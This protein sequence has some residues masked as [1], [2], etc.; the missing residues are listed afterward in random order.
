MKVGY[1]APLP[2]VRSGVADYAADLLAALRQHCEPVPNGGGDTA[3]YQLGNNQM[4]HVIFQRALAE[5]GVI[6]L[7][8]A[9]L[10]HYHLGAL[11]EARYVSEFVK[12]YGT[13]FEDYAAMLWRGRAHSAS[14]PRYFEY[15]LLRT[16]ISRSRA[17]IVHNAA[18][19]RIATNEGAA[20]KLHVI[21]HLLPRIRPAHAQAVTRLR[22]SLGIAAGSTLFAVFGHLR[23]SKRIAGVVRAFARVHALAPHVR[24]LIAGESVSAPYA[25]ALE[26]LLDT[27]GI[28]RAGHLSEGD[29][30]TYASAADVCI[31]LRYPSCGETSGI[32]MRLMALGKPVLVTAGDEYGGFP[33]S[34]CIRI[35]PG[36]A[37]EEHLAQWMTLLHEN[38]DWATRI[39]E[40]GRSHVALYHAPDRVGRMVFDVLS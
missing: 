14:D 17:V 26:Q 38:R 3:L 10:H 40:N 2:P 31:N 15:P 33:E 39:G 11:N 16:V 22:Q 8:D 20:G 19:A 30:W 9:N 4:H 18:A 12:Q 24:L 27:P 7:H 23:E 35:L 5:P 28:L 6:L 25:A 32:G 13:W 36:H 34:A 21:P 1:Y 29:F 37:E